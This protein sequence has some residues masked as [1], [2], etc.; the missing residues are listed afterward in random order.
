MPTENRDEMEIDL[1]EL[2]RVLMQ[3]AV[4]IIL[5]LVIGAGASGVVTKMFITPQYSASSMI[6]ILTK[7]TSVT[8]LADI[9]MGAQLTTDF[10]TLALS[11]PVVEGV[12]DEL[13]LN[14]DYEELK[15]KIKVENLT[16]TRILRITV[17]DADPKIA[18][19]ISNAMADATADQVADI[20]STDR[21]SIVEK[22]VVAEQPSSPSLKKNVALGGILGMFLCMAVII[23]LYLLDDTVK[24]E[25]DVQKYLK[26]N[27]LAAFPLKSESMMESNSRAVN[28]KRKKARQKK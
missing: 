27:T 18:A 16:D 26:L 10:A 14:L 21:P 28:R 8:S 13:G 15:E 25:E 23:G 22:A 17:E 5:C 12:I 4:I 6:Y 9:Q 2:A 19:E 20:M 7:T 24:T 1:L 3:K 11:R